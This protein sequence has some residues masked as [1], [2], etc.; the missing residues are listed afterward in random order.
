VLAHPVP[1]LL[2]IPHVSS[3][4]GPVRSRGCD[5]AKPK[6]SS[7][8]P[9]PVRSRGCEAMAVEVSHSTF[10][11]WRNCAVSGSTSTLRTMP[12]WKQLRNLRTSCA[13]R[14]STKVILSCTISRSAFVD[15]ATCHFTHRFAVNLSH[16]IYFILYV[17]KL[18]FF[19]DLSLSTLTIGS[20]VLQN[21]LRRKVL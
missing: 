8:Y 19:L 6:C 11:Y 14:W 20:I 1:S 9:G 12:R 10:P 13:S 5:T 2:L 4:P 3:G 7:L 17:T 15:R 16:K 21:D 18:V